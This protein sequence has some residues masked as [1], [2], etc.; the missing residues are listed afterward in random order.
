MVA[1][2][3]AFA[4]SYASVSRM[5]Q[6][7]VVSSSLISAAKLA[8]VA[9]AASLL[10]GCAGMGGGG[11]NFHTIAYAPTN[12]DDVK[13]KVSLKTQNVYVEEGDRLLMGA[14]TCTGKPG[15]PTPVGN[16]A[17]EDKIQ[18][19]RSSEYGYWTN[20][21]ETHPGT[22]GQ[23]R[24]PGWRY[25]GYPMAY[26]VEFTPGFGFHEGPI[27]PYPRSHGCLHLHEAT[28][29]KFW[30]LVHIGTPVEVAYSLP[31][32]DKW[33]RSIERPTDY[34]DPDPAP[35]LMISD[36]WFTKPR[37]SELLPPPST[38]PA[39]TASASSTGAAP[40]M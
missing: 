29:V 19:K 5:M 30:K 16:F 17:V 26:W 2:S 20:G 37:D 32:D 22:A 40:A 33:G 9:L 14:P 15:Y 24:G 8:C 3:F 23:S 39:P 35:S 4:A 34:A 10:A 36:E 27:W 28:V 25:V 12:P 6:K 11:G 21:N 38:T 1:D 7:S 31:E 18:D 13:V